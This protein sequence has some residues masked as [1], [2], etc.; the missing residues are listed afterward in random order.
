[1][2]ANRALAC[3]LMAGLLACLLGPLPPFCARMWSRQRGRSW[4]ALTAAV[5]LPLK[6]GAREGGSGTPRLWSAISSSS[7][8]PLVGM[9]VATQWFFVSVPRT[10]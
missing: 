10:A 9:S 2:V 8:R 1:M 6:T 3:L 7:V 4:V 5:P